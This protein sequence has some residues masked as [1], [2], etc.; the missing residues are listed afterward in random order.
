[1]RIS[2]LSCSL[3]AIACTQVALAAPI[4]IV[5]GGRPLLV[6]AP[7]GY[8]DANA[9][10]TRETSIIKTQVSAG[11][12]FL[13]LFYSD[14]DMTS[15][16]SGNSPASG[17]YFTVVTEREK[18]WRNLNPDDPLIGNAAVKNAYAGLLARDGAKMKMLMQEITA[19]SPTAVSDP[20]L[21]MNI[22]DAIVGD[23][24]IAAPNALGLLVVSQPSRIIDGE[25]VVYPMVSVVTRVYLKRKVVYLAVYSPFHAITDLEWVKSASRQ[26][27]AETNKL[28]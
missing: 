27:V 18:E 19:S 28:N 22:G 20:T 8:Q 5:V 16:H 14:A 1:M 4:T 6:E 17:R 26:W 9:T 13:A 2:V 21:S 25:T 12:R 24:W 11:Q 23:M 3:L 10:D 7:V 15:I